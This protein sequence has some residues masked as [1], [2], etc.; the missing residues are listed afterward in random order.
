MFNDFV[1]LMRYNWYTSWFAGLAIT[2]FGGGYAA[3][4][5]F[6]KG[7]PA[8]VLFTVIVSMGVWLTDHILGSVL[9]VPWVQAEI[10]EQQARLR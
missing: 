3:M 5:I 7:V 9:D 6:G 10:A 1:K 2:I 8:A 4:F